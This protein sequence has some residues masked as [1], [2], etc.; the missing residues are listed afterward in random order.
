MEKSP[1]CFSADS[2]CPNFVTCDGV[3][4]RAIEYS[5]Y[6]SQCTYIVCITKTSPF[7]LFSQVNS[8]S[9]NNQTKLNST[10]WIKMQ[11][12][13]CFVICIY[14]YIYTHIY[15]KISSVNLY[16]IT[17]TY[18]AVNTP[19]SGSLQFVLAKVVNY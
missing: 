10:L 9:S 19:S 16:K 1:L 18:F 3:L 17:P 14:I 4:K 8:L 5:G 7:I 11:F 6:T 15:A 2:H 13:K 12:F